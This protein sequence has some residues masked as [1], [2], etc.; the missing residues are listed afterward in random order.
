M[1][2]AN[3]NK[4]KKQHRYIQQKFEVAFHVTLHCQINGLVQLS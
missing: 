1:V 2:T 4:I 3:Y